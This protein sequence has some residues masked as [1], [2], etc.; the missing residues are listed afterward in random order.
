ME[1]TRP[2]AT[3]IDPEP[4]ETVSDR[5]NALLL[6]SGAGYTLS[7]CP[8]K[9]YY[10]Q[11]PL[12]FAAEDQEISTE[13]Y[14]LGQ[15][16]ATLIVSG[17][18]HTVAVDGTRPGSS[19]AMLRN[20]QVDGNRRDAPIIS[21]GANIVFGGVNENQT[22]QYVRSFDPRSW[23]CLHVT[24]GPLSCNNV[25]VQN[26]DI[27][28]C[29]VEFVDEWADGIS[30]SCRNSVVRDNLIMD[31]TDG[32]IVIFGSPGTQVYN[33]TIWVTNKTLLGGINM[34]DFD[35]WQGNYTDTVVRNNTIIGGYA[36]S[37]GSTN[38]GH[39]VI[40]IGI[41]I[42]PRIWFGDQYLDN[43]TFAGT[44]TGNR[45]SGAFVY[46]IAMSASE[47]FTV[48]ENAMFGNYTFI[49]GS[50]PDCLDNGQF[51]PAPAAFIYDSSTSTVPLQ[52]DFQYVRDGDLL[53]CMLPPA[54]GSY[55]PHGRAPTFTWS[56]HLEESW[57]AAGVAVADKTSWALGTVFV[58][59][60]GVAVWALWR[61]LTQRR[62][63]RPGRLK[64][65]ASNEIPVHTR[66]VDKR[67]LPA[68]QRKR[69]LAF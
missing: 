2:V 11:G 33:N 47:N 65:T 9:R 45:L 69:T 14:P 55:W 31:A 8:G 1:T 46:G 59:G 26:N 19:G 12:V 28:P 67:A 35:P 52:S 36:D 41:A 5:I 48:H 32:G 57:P 24:E 64:R 58:L 39:A 44:V 30:V 53:T 51:V 66:A 63:S 15:Q 56:G 49:G 68:H 50:G 6:G 18:D 27:G 13:G 22:I 34:V 62:R 40:K 7:L 10:I 21:G 43:M 16:R 60:L 54:G 42:G 23:S 37:E 29:G 61:M 20:V 25:T 4:A 3:C 38:S 17:S